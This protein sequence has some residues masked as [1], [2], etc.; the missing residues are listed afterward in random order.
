MTRTEHL[1]V[2]LMEECNEVSQRAA[3]ALRFGLSEVQPEQDA[4]NAQRLAS[5]MAD[6]IGTWRLLAFEGRVDPISMFGDSPAKKA[7]KIEKY[8]K[9]SAECGTLEG[10]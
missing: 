9:Y 3:K 4:T 1:L 8:L 2:V 5:E 6:L 10:T 7:E